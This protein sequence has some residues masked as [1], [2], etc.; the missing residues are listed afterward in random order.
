MAS[1]IARARAL[2]QRLLAPEEWLFTHL[3]GSRPVPNSR[4]TFLVACHKHHGADVRLPDGTAVR[5]GE[6][7]AEIHFWNQHIAHRG[8][9]HSDPTTITWRLARDFRADLGALARAME[10]GEVAADAVA[11]YGASPIAPAAAR[12]GFLVRP[13]PPGLRRS[14][15]SFWQRLLRR[16]FRP[17]AAPKGHDAATAE[18][19]MSRSEFLRRFTAGGTPPLAERTERPERAAP[20]A[21]PGTGRQGGWSV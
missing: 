8:D 15:L 11:V 5:R 18:M 1:P 20:A 6:P 19:W 10:R 16:V 21:P 7:V 12:F 3:M 9:R 14:M 13:L 4:G 17:E 2:A